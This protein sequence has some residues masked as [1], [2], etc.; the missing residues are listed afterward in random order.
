MRAPEAEGAIAPGRVGAAPGRS[1]AG[2]HKDG[3]AQT[4]IHLLATRGHLSAARQL[5]AVAPRLAGRVIPLDYERLF[6]AMTPAYWW[7]R[8]KESYWEIANHGWWPPRTETARVA[9]T[10]GVRLYRYLRAPRRAKPG[11]YIFA[12][13]ELLSPADLQKAVVLW[14]S[15]ADGGPGIRLLNH[16][17]RSMRRYE[18]LRTLHERGINRF[19]VYRLTEARWPAQYPVF[20]RREGDHG[21]PTSPL[22]RT[23]R[24]L[25]GA[26]HALRRS[27]EVRDGVVV[28]EF[29]DTADARGLYRKYGAFVVGD[30]VFPKSLQFSRHWVQKGSDLHDA[31]LL[32]EERAYV[33]G[34]PHEE[35]LRRIFQLARIEYGRM[36]YA[37]LDG[38]IQVWEINTNP[39]V[40]S[41]GPRRIGARAPVY[42]HVAKTMAKALAVLV[43]EPVAP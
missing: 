29:C 15:L 14:Q 28:V 4:R 36:D 41:H 13:L 37:L 39:T 12:D 18:L 30:R 5:E 42:E 17:A 26:L 6:D 43:D 32:R 16:P 19:D 21:G 33:E 31:E 27:G 2:P 1:A 3:R 40:T 22:L 8:A 38:E 35:A 23:R 7:S 34:N 10:V 24:E 25:E 20:L 11:T 9:V